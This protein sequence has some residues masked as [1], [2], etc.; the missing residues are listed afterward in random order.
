MLV[1]PRLRTAGRAPT[2][3]SSVRAVVPRQWMPQIVGPGR[4]GRFVRLLRVVTGACEIAISERRR[5]LVAPDDRDGR[6]AYAQLTTSMLRRPHDRIR[7]DFRLVDRRHRLRG[8]RQPALT[9]S[10]C[11]VFIAGR[12]T[13]V[14]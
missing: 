12:F 14:T 3:E 4:I 11:G 9:Q 5:D 13:V 2:G 8:A 10:N 7:G 1:D 6:H